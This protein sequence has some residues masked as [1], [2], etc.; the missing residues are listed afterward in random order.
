MVNSLVDVLTD[1]DSG[2]HQ[3]VNK[4]VD[5]LIVKV[6]DLAEMVKL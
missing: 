1:R 5:R 4:G 3:T 2:D 6:W